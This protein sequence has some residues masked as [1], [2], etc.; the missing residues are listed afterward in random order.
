M[1]S[2]KKSGICHQMITLHML[3]I[4]SFT[5]IIKAPILKCEYL[6]NSEIFSCVTFIEVDI[7][8]WIVNVVLCDLDLKCGCQNFETLISWRLGEL[9]QNCVISLYDFYGG[10]YLP[11]NSNIVN[12]VFCDLDLHF[13]GQTCS[14]YVFIIKKMRRQQMSP[15]DLPRRGV[16]L[17]AKSCFFYAYLL[18]DYIVYCFQAL[19]IVS[20]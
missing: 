10:W 9:S 11:T 19:Y 6:K 17:V 1:L 14:Y 18:T 8:H 15:A 13:Q 4:M 7:C 2:D 16:A 5:C 12:V 20:K 3:Y